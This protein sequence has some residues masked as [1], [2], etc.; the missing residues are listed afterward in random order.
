M[1]VLKDEEKWYLDILWSTL[2]CWDARFNFFFNS[3]Q[4]THKKQDEKLFHTCFLACDMFWLKK[5][6]SWNLKMK[7]KICFPLHKMKMKRETN[8]NWRD[9][10]HSSS[11]VRVN[12]CRMRNLWYCFHN[13]Y[14]DLTFV[15]FAS[16]IT[17]LVEW[18][19]IFK[20]KHFFYSISVRETYVN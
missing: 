1:R 15:S 13:V 16:R 12:K 5:A 11:V 6:T 2:S 20:W 3:T 9:I 8:L 19:L 18:D 7:R 10:K 14:D 4:S 17:E